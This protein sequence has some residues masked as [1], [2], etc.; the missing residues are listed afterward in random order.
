MKL[1]VR[2][3]GEQ[4]ARHAEARDEASV[5]CLVIGVVGMGPEDLTSRFCSRKTPQGGCN[6]QRRR[7]AAKA[8]TRNVTAPDPP[9]KSEKN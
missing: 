7:E 8:P 5:L 3:G 2:E 4:V 9:I 6:E 1:E